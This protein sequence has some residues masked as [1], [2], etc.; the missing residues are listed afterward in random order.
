MHEQFQAPTL[1]SLPPFMAL[2][3]YYEQQQQQ[4]GWETVPL[5][6]KFELK[7][8]GELSASQLLREETKSVTQERF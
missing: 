4:F 7:S 2:E 5:A 6:Q 1:P 3:L 8:L